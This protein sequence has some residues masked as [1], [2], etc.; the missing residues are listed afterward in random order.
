MNK[1]QKEQNSLQE[2]Y[3]VNEYIGGDKCVVIDNEGNNLG[4]L[5]KRKTIE[6]AQG[7]G[8]DA[9]QV[10]EKDDV[11]VVRIMDF[12]K[13]L[14]E[15][16]KQLGDSKKHQKIMQLKEIK[17]RPNIGDQDFETKMKQAVEFFVD[18]K[19]VKFTLQF[20]GREIGMMNDL[21][22]KFFERIKQYLELKGVGTLVEEKEQRAETNWAK[23][24]FVKAKK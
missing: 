21:G 22:P 14:Y 6:L 2:K 20:K 4:V 11:P 1:F 7:V 16:K 10:G 19:K 13:F 24:F 9:V 18:G 12:G 5:P 3:R 15:K 8:L 17:L 23:I